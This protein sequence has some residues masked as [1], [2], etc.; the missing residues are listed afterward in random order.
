MFTIV[1][2]SPSSVIQQK[3]LARFVLLR[4]WNKNERATH[5]TNGR[6]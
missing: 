4:A 2:L 6:K 1:S 3:L 5:V